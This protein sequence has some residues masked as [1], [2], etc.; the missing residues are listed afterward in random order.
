[1]ANNHLL[2]WD[3][4]GETWLLPF[5]T[6]SANRQQALAFNTDNVNPIIN[7]ETV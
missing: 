1:M 6:A 2:M 7:P 4:I 5:L 3:V